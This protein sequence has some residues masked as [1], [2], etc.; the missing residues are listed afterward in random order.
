MNLVATPTATTERRQLLIVISMSSGGQALSDRHLWLMSLLKAHF[1]RNTMDLG[2]LE[3][4]LE[5]QVILVE[6]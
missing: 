1:G 4:L 2:E 6:H 3:G 5:I